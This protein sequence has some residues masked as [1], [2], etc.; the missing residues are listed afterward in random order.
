M[1]RPPV[2]PG[3]LAISKSRLQ[4]LYEVCHRRL[5]KLAIGMYLSPLLIISVTGRTD[6][7]ACR[8]Q[9]MR[10][11]VSESWCSDWGMTVDSDAPASLSATL[12]DIY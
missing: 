8:A 10:S 5:Q 12:R 1:V 4:Y 3:A 6:G 11:F 2:T 9:E 7:I